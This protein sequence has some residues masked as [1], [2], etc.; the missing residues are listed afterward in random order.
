[1]KICDNMSIIVN[2]LQQC[3][4]S[5]PK[6]SSQFRSTKASY[7]QWCQ[8]W[9]CRSWLAVTPTLHRAV[10]SELHVLHRANAGHKSQ[11]LLQPVGR[12]GATFG[13]L[14]HRTAFVATQGLVI[15]LVFLLLPILKSN[16]TSFTFIVYFF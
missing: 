10:P 8:V 4:W 7:A 13:M 1:M 14:G 11:D 2:N 15:F 9:N 6:G 12:E 3:Y 16:S 5:S